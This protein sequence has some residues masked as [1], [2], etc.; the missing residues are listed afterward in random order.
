MYIDQTDYLEM[1]CRPL[2]L[3]YSKKIK[4]LKNSFVKTVSVND[5]EG[6]QYE[7]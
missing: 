2:A 4:K 7:L 6:Y 3:E 5:A 1:R